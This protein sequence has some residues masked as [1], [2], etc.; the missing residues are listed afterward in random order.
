[1]RAGCAVVELRLWS[2]EP[3]SAASMSEGDVRVQPV[4][5]LHPRTIALAALGVALGAAQA[6]CAS[7]QV[8]GPQLDIVLRTQMGTG[9]VTT[10]PE[11][12]PH[13]RYTF[14]S[15]EDPTDCLAGIQL[16]DAEGK[17]RGGELFS[18]QAPAANVPTVLVQQD[19]PDGDYRLRVATAAPR[20]T[21]MVEEV[22]NSMSSQDPPPTAEPAPPAPNDAVTVTS[23]APGP[24][25][26]TQPGL[27]RVGWAVTLR[28]GAICSYNLNLRTAAGDMEHIDQKPEPTGPGQPTDQPPGGPGGGAFGGVGM[29]VFL[30]AGTRTVSAETPC[31]WQLSIEPLTGPNGGGVRGFATPKP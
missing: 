26:I 13:A 10:A 27:Y 23:A 18:R 2:V 5:G 14:F 25:S 8:H 16:L 28:P 17:V 19:V 30:A 15:W 3:R 9:A 11:H 4:R 22:L 20:C 12:L 29:S 1:M 31:P 7:S 24:I 6:G 21:W